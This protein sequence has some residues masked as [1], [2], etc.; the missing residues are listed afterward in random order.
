MS[1]L[2]LE[3]LNLIL[4][5]RIGSAVTQLCTLKALNVEST[6]VDLEI[7]CKIIKNCP[8]LAELSIVNYDQ[9]DWNYEVLEAAALTAENRASNSILKIWVDGKFWKAVNQSII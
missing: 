9:K 1:Q 6:F 2:P 4:C 7:L 8:K 5:N 3:E